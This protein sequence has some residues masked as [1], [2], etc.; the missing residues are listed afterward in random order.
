MD[1]KHS[2][3]TRWVAAPIHLAISTL[4]ASIVFA[5]IYFV[6]YPGA[7]FS[8]AGGR[9]LFLLIVSVDITLGPLVTLIVF[10]PGKKGLRFD[11]AVIATVQLAAL[12][13]GV[14]VLFESRPVWIVYV[15]DRYELVR[16]NEVDDADRAKAK[17]PYD[18]L[19]ITGP[20]LVAGATSRPIPDEQLRVMH[21]RAEGPRPAG[22]TRSTSIRTTAARTRGLRP[23]QVARCR[24]CAS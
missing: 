21:D 19:S 22:A 18:G 17:P 15:K 11:L 6:W 4:L 14:W 20:K 23:R 7:L 12:A 5:I 13:Y 16:A 2:R 9:E 1:N 24:A 10:V 8:A 3:M